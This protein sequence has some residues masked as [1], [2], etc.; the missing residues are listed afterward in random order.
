MNDKRCPV[1]DLLVQ[2]E[3]AQCSCN[4]VFFDDTPEHVITSRR[5]SVASLLLV[6]AVGMGVFIGLNMQSLGTDPKLTLFI[7]SGAAFSLNLLPHIRKQGGAALSIAL[8]TI[9]WSSFLAGKTWREVY[10]DGEV[11]VF[12]D[13]IVYVRDLSQPL[14]MGGHQVRPKAPRGIDPSRKVVRDKDDQ[15]IYI[16]QGDLS[17]SGT[18]LLKP[19]DVVEKVTAKFPLESFESGVLNLP[20]DESV[21]IIEKDGFIEQIYLLR[22]SSKLGSSAELDGLRLG[23]SP[24]L[25]RA[26][27][28]RQKPVPTFSTRYDRI[29]GDEVIGIQG[30]TY[31][32]E[33]GDVVKKGQAKAT[34][35]NLNEKKRPPFATVEYDEK[36]RVRHISLGACTDG[37]FF[38]PILSSDWTSDFKLKFKESFAFEVDQSNQPVKTAEVWTYTGSSYKGIDSLVTLR[39]L[40]KVK[41][42]VLTEPPYHRKQTKTGWEKSSF[43]LGRQSKWMP[44]YKYDK[45]R[46]LFLH[47]SHFFEIVAVRGNEM[48][49]TMP[50]K[51]GR[52]IIATQKALK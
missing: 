19:G 48:L 38:P 32:S 6:L 50:P 37:S 28:D 26:I 49:Q 23:M 33:G 30:H 18:V 51:L 46:L 47:E 17:Q 2:E 45:S 24:S 42:E 40:P 21:Y 34:V 20:Y 31:R 41:A 13:Q 36:E 39:R 15:V 7:I 27:A 14:E 5:L 9:L 22:G 52:K 1:C 16:T 43:Q 8:V 44:E 12:A 3:R 35:P 29:R 11:G 10:G 25:A 4:F